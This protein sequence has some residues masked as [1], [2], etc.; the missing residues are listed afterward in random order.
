[1]TAAAGGNEGRMTEAWLMEADC[2]HGVT[3]Y[4][5]D[6]CERELRD[7]GAEAASSPV[8]ITEVWTDP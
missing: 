8:V 7:L 1:M 6:A 4:E 3:W 5:C 2:I